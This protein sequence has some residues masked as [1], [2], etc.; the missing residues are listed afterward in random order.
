MCYKID[1]HEIIWQSP[2]YRAELELRQA[3]LRRPLGLD[4]YR[5]DLAAEKA[6]THIGA[7]HGE[8]LVGVLMVKA[9]CGGQVQLRQAAVLEAYRGRGIG[10][11]LFEFAEALCGARG[12]RKLWLNAR[13]TA[14]GFYLRLGYLRVGAEFLEL[15]IPHIRMEKSLVCGGP[16]MDRPSGQ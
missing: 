2:A 16:G 1:Y 7:F 4:L 8:D 11:G 3:I 13:Q 9:P 14:E 10:A 5:E 15:G 6:D 12:Y